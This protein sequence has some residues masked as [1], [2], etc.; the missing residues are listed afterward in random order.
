MSRKPLVIEEPDYITLKAIESVLGCV[1]D[2]LYAPEGE[3]KEL[4]ENILKSEGGQLSFKYNKTEFEALL[5]RCH[6]V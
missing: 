4:M 1:Y 6:R 5:N 2:L 3:R